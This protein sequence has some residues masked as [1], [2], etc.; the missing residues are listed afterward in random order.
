[1]VEVAPASV[2]VDGTVHNGWTCHVEMVSDGDGFDC[3]DYRAV[4][5]DGREKSLDWGRF[6][7]FNN[8]HFMAFVEANFPQSPNSG[9]WWPNEIEGLPE[10]GHVIDRTHRLFGDNGDERISHINSSQ[11]ES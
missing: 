1:M 11:G 3:P 5:D 7:R 6:R 2:S 4:H 9:P 10:Y 8:L